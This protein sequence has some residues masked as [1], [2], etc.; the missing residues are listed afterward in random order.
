MD[1]NIYLINQKLHEE[2]GILRHL[3]NPGAPKQNGVVERNNCMLAN[4]VT[5]M[6]AQANVPIKF[7]VDSLLAEAYVLN[8]MLLSQFLTLHMKL[9]TT[10][11]F[12][13]EICTTGMLTKYPECSKG[14]VIFGEHL[15][16]GMTNEVQRY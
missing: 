2:K 5:S 1:V 14:F 12:N 13:L 7:W 3:R 6:M 15:D 4:M 10:A 9:M 16:R 11:K 8:R